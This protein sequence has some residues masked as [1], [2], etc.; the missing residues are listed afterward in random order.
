MAFIGFHWCGNR[1]IAT[2]PAFAWDGWTASDQV[3]RSQGCRRVHCARMN[4]P[5][6]RLWKSGRPTRHDSGTRPITS[7]TCALCGQV[8]SPRRS[9]VTS[10]LARLIVLPSIGV[11]KQ[12]PVARSEPKLPYIFGRHS[13][14]SEQI[15]GF[16]RPPPWNNRANTKG[17]HP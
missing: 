10:R 1:S 17:D 4:A 12:C 13:Q 3:Y 7:P 2:S 9:R 11:R 6:R 8:A 5:F 15:A 16:R 14:N